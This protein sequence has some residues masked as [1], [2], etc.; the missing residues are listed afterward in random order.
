[1]PR[2]PQRARS[3][4]KKARKHISRKAKSINTVQVKPSQD[5]PLR[6]Q[7]VGHSLG[8]LTRLMRKLTKALKT[9]VFS[10]RQFVWPTPSNFSCLAQPPADL[11][12]LIK[13]AL[14][15]TQPSF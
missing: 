11:I 10:L 8:F 7:L 9:L 4:Q 13:S 15:F 5:D 14:P 2:W 12:S 3:I 1:M 6:W